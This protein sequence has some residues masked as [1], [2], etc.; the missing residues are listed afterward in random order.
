MA[1]LT[2]DF[3]EACT[4]PPVRGTLVLAHPSGATSGA[5]KAG[6]TGCPGQIRAKRNPRARP[7][8]HCARPSTPRKLRR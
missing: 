5:R 3:L 8:R 1:I 4:L 2:V 6:S 7:T